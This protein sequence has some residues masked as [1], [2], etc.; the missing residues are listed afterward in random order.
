MHTERA[1]R[2]KPPVIFVHG[3]ACDLSDWQ[4]PFDRLKEDTTVIACDLRGHGSSPGDAAD[5]S[6][7]TYGADVASLIAELDLP[8]AI[9]VGHSMGCRVVLESCRTAPDRV[10]GIVLVDGSAIAAGER[11]AAERGMSDQLEARGYDEFI[12]SF[13]DGMFTPASDPKLKSTIIERALQLPADIGMSL[14]P[15]LAGWDAAQLRAALGDVRVPLMAIQ[16]TSLNSERVRVPLPADETS[17]WLDLVRN[18]VPSARIETL[19]DQGHFPHV[20]MPDEVSAL[21]S[22]FVTGIRSG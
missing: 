13:F 3:F 6:I 2:G 8:P 11:S 9:L 12:R 16:T 7:E 18:H 4:A 5:C 14:L 15:R 19:A 20:E 17:A 22:D 1:G 21:I 10:A